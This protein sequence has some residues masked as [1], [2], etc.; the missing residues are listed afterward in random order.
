MH[1]SFDTG[2]ES[3]SSPTDILTL[4]EVMTSHSSYKFLFMV[5]QFLKNLVARVLISRI[6]FLIMG[7]LHRSSAKAQHSLGSLVKTHY[8]D[9]KVF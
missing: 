5:Q 9:S 1:L 8:G 3:G 6:F 2:T 7:F 4:E